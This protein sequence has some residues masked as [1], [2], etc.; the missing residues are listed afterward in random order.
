MQAVYFGGSRNLPV[1]PLIPQVVRSV[2]RSGCAV[3]V[4]CQFGADA[5]IMQA[6][7]IAPSFLIVFAL[8][9]SITTTPPHVQRAAALG[10]SVTLAA[11]GRSAPMRAR[12]LLRSLAALRG[13][14]QAI[15]FQP[16]R[17]SLAVASHAAAAGLPVF[18][19]AAEAPAPIPNQAGAW[20]PISPESYYA[21]FSSPCFTWQP[22][23]TQAAMI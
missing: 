8:A 9:P 1:S 11:G 22:L 5:Q 14:G 4:G 13:C 3:H 18:A 6:A 16:G 19:F 7:S 10:A 12:Y 2:I 23:A 17:G 15:F 20:L 21:A